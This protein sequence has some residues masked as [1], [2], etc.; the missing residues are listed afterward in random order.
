MGGSFYPS[1]ARFLIPPKNYEVVYKLALSTIFLL[2]T[3]ISSRFI[4]YRKYSKILFSFFAFSIAINL[5]VVS[6]YPRLELKP[7]DNS[8]LRM[9]MSTG[10]V[11]ISLIILHRVSGDKPH[12]IFISKGNSRRGLILGLTGFFIFALV[13]I[14]LATFQFQGQNLRIAGF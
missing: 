12:D 5:Q 1:R 10:L 4:R 2:F 6:A 13:S 8:V 9:L 11:V 3:I 14:P 7:I